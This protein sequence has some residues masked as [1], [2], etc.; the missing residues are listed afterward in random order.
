MLVSELSGRLQDKRI[1]TVFESGAPLFPQ[2]FH[3]ND[4][5]V[6]RPDRAVPALGSL[7]TRSKYRQLI[8]RHRTIEAICRTGMSESGEQVRSSL[9]HPCALLGMRQRIVSA[10]ERFC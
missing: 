6:R 9:H 5:A 7:G 10:L 2:I 3:D 1:L 8:R 4:E